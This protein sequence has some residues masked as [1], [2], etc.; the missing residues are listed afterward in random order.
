MARR[1][2]IAVVG[3]LGERHVRQLPNGM[4]SMDVTLETADGPLHLTAPYAG[5]LL[6][7]PYDLLLAVN[8]E[9]ERGWLTGETTWLRQAYAYETGEC[10]YSSPSS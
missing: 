9:H 1:T 2:A 4:V 10:V 8:A 3:T 6:A 7:I 5:E